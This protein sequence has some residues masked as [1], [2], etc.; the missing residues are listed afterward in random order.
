[1]SSKN[2]NPALSHNRADTTL[3]L[4][5]DG[6]AAAPTAVAS[7]PLET[8]LETRLASH[9]RAWSA[10]RVFDIGAAG[11]AL[12]VLSPLVALIAV[13][14]V[15]D[16]GRPVF[17]RQ[18]RIGRYGV[19]FSIWKFRTMIPDRRKLDLGAPPGMPE[20]RHTH[21]SVE[22][23][24]QTRVGRFLRRSCLDEI[25]QFWNALRGEMSIVGP[26]PELPDIVAGYEPWQHA[27]H[28]VP[29]GIT[30]WWQVNR[31]AHVPM[32]RAT[33]LDLYYVE[34]W[35]PWL[36]LMILVRTAGVVVRGIGSF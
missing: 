9:P 36:D 33:H 11:A 27:R 22:D 12:A 35:S 17:F 3:S 20:R 14:I 24:R 13:A 6:T 19:P 16:S 31:D 23:P 10:K 15:L 8:S 1:V 34:H 29:P 32:H 2:Y 18:Q 25:P 5:S 4:I 7:P 26:R 21:K 28:L 30:G